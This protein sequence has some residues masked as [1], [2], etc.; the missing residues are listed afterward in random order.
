MRESLEDR[1]R[2]LERSNRRLKLL[3]GLLAVTAVAC[4]SGN[5]AI[6]GLVRTEKLDI[7]DQSEAARMSLSSSGGGQV[8]FQDGEGQ[9]KLDAATLRQLLASAQTPAPPS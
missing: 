3:G 6:F 8:V 4:G 1:I 2:R 7:I 5:T 9:V